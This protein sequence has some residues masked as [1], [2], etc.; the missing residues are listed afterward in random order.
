M[1]YFR[2]NGEQILFHIE[3]DNAMSIKDFYFLI[4]SENVKLFS[5]KSR[6]QM[7]YHIYCITIC[8]IL[9][10]LHHHSEPYNQLQNNAPG[11]TPLS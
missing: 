11:R 8:I 3:W 6:M 5:F 2:S 7:Y 1:I 4:V 9:V 10:A